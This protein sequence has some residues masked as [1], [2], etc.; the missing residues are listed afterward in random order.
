MPCKLI[1]NIK[2]TTTR[3]Q[4]LRDSKKQIMFMSYSRKRIIKG[5]KFHSRN[6]VGSARILSRKCYQTTIIWYAK[7]EPTRRKC[8]TECECVNSHPAKHQPTYESTRKNTNPIPKWSLITTI[9]M[10]GRGSI[11]MNSQFLT[12]KIMMQPSPASAKFQYSLTCQRGK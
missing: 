5:V 2:L 10:P 8:C 6:F 4:T 7:L 12:P 3:R 1:L 11:I 9:C